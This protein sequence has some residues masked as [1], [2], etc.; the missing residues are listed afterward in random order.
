MGCHKGE[1]FVLD[2]LL[3]RHNVA[4]HIPDGFQR[5]AAL[6]VKG[7]QNFLCLGADS[8]LVGDVVGDRPHF[9]PVKLLGVQPHP[10]VQVGF[11]NVQVHHTGVRASDL[12]KVGV[13]EAA[14]HLRGLA[15]IVDLCLHG[16]V[17][18]LHHAGDH[19]MALA[20]AL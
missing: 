5:G 15:P 14:A 11:V 6:D 12:R 13:A 16:G 17:A 10:V 8:S 19:G 9:F 7:V 4:R 2:P 3:K 18:A 20:C 1:L